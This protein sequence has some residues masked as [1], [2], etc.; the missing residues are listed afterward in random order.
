MIKLFLSFDF[1]Y[2]LEYNASF[3]GSGNGSALYPFLGVL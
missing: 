2:F 3:L 1:L